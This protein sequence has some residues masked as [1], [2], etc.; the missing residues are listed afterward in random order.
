MANFNERFVTTTIG[1]LYLNTDTALRDARRDK[2]KYKDVLASIKKHGIRLKPVCRPASMDKNAPEGKDYQIVDGAQRTGCLKDAMSEL[3]KS[4]HPDWDAERIVQEVLKTPIVISVQDI[5]DNEMNTMMVELNLHRI[6]NDKKEV[7]SML[8]RDAA[9]N[10]GIK[11]IELAKKYNVDENYVSRILNYNK[12]A[13]DIKEQV[14]QLPVSTVVGLGKLDHDKQRELLQDGLSDLPSNEQITTIKAALKE[15]E[16]LKKGELP[17]YHQ[18]EP[19]YV[20]VKLF[21]EKL[22]AAQQAGNE[23]FAEGLRASVGL[24]AAALHLHRLEWEEKQAAKESKKKKPVT[25]A[26]QL[27][28]AE[29]EAEKQRKKLEELRAMATAGV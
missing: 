9:D 15:Q 10:P 29:A 16:A 13:E 6:A 25:I 11:G 5:P 3:Y 23:D 12:I 2:A 7:A 20:G 24:D 8:L 27:A 17:T 14:E 19:R 18:P 22:E 4:Q 26:E 21:R 28:A 1:K